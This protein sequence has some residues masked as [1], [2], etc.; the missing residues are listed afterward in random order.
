MDQL[1]Q[2]PIEDNRQDFE[3]QVDDNEIYQLQKLQR[4]QERH[5]T[6]EEYF[7]EEISDFTDELEKA[8]HFAMQEEMEGAI[9]SKDAHMQTNV[10]YL[11][12][13]WFS[14][15]NKVRTMV[16]SLMNP[17]LRRA[18]EDRATVAGV[19]QI[20]DGLKK[21]VDELLF[22]SAKMTT[23]G[24]QIEEIASRMNQ[25]EADKKVYEARVGQELKAM[26]SNI[27]MC[28]EK[29]SV[30]TNLSNGF[31]KQ[32]EILRMEVSSF[33]EE[34]N[35]VKANFSKELQAFTKE[36]RI[37][38]HT[39]D[40]K[41]KHLQEQ[42]QLVK[43]YTTTHEDVIKKTDT[44]VETYKKQLEELYEGLNIALTTKLDSSI[45][46]G[47]LD[48]ISKDVYFVKVIAQDV[49]NTINHIEHYL[50]KYQQVKTQNQITEAMV[51]VLPRKMIKRLKKYTSQR[52]SL[53]L[54]DIKS[55][56]LNMKSTLNKATFH[57]PQIRDVLVNKAEGNLVIE[58]DPSDLFRRTVMNQTQNSLQ[59]STD[60]NRNQ[61]S[62]RYIITYPDLS[63]HDQEK[64]T[65]NIR[66]QEES[67]S[68]ERDQRFGETFKSM[69]SMRSSKSKWI[70][71]ESGAS[72]LN[73]PMKFRMKKA[74]KIHNLPRRNP[75]ISV[76]ELE[77]SV[78]KR[79]LDHNDHS[80]SRLNASK[81]HSN[82][83]HRKSIQVRA[84]NV[85]NQFAKD[86]VLESFKHEQ[87]LDLTDSD[88]FD[89]IS[90]RKIELEDLNDEL[91]LKIKGND[92]VLDKIREEQAEFKTLIEMRIEILRS[93]TRAH[94]ENQL[95]N[96]Q[97]EIENKL[98][99]KEEDLI[100]LIQVQ[101]GLLENEKVRRAREKSDTTIEIKK[102]IQSGKKASKLCENVQTGLD[103]LAEMIKT[104]I[105]TTQISQALEIQDEVDRKSIALMGYQLDNNNQFFSHP[106]N[107]EKN[108]KQ[109]RKNSFFNDSSLIT[110]GNGNN[111]SSM[112]IDPLINQINNHQQTVNRTLNISKSLQNLTTL[113]PK[114]PLLRNIMEN[115]SSN[116]VVSINKD[117]ISCSN[118][119]AIVIKGFKMACLSYQSSPLT[120]KGQTYDRQGLIS[121]KGQ[122]LNRTWNRLKQK[123]PWCMETNNTR[124]TETDT[125]DMDHQ[126]FV[127][128]TL[129]DR[130]YFDDQP[131]LNLFDN[132]IIKGIKNNETI[133]QQDPLLK[134]D[135][136]KIGM[137]NSNKKQSLILPKIEARN[138]LIN[139]STSVIQLQKDFEQ[140]QKLVIE[141]YQT[142]GGNLKDKKLSSKTIIKTVRADPD[143]MKNQKEEYKLAAGFMTSRS[144]S[145]HT[146]MGR[147][148][149]F[150]Q[151]QS[152]MLS[153]GHIGSALM[154]TR[155]ITNLDRTENDQEPQSPQSDIDNNLNETKEDKIGNQYLKRIIQFSKQNDS[156]SKM[157][158]KLWK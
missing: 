66:P 24:G 40:Q 150:H 135:D 100:R 97:I 114:Q 34:I 25:V 3:I 144:M 132:E 154:A 43:G 157:L 53:F 119:T 124:D 87:H 70:K 71:R 153:S 94:V 77:N 109:D 151:S 26:S 129:L 149:A 86:K 55:N 76:N 13:D 1:E 16:L 105:E 7:N 99:A 140:R 158:K 128:N 110:G 133:L 141:N 73:S 98:K 82:N 29:I 67:S 17:F 125:T 62:K 85:H 27:Q 31:K 103:N 130:R 44:I 49:D 92:E 19:K 37:I 120:F 138:L 118:Q 95:Y 41:V 142:L 72:G 45:F 155:S 106:L 32:G 23:R 152:D 108:T 14:M 54:D 18:E 143:Q 15:Q 8:S 96:K 4:H 47:E 35:K 42:F 146:P 91:L 148:S 123:V 50:D 61:L 52:Y 134:L 80:H 68:C 89:V 122:I 60:N 5:P 101:E 117:C 48:K 22:I 12:F 36:L 63:K 137:E 75:D 107:Q 90:E 111:D 104:I 6:Q 116:N 81:K 78:E 156:S 33:Y 10:K 9:A 136:I 112:L 102:A 56:D 145:K 65:V 131:S 139:S 74:L 21:K 46:K 121:I 69:R 51:N 127:N 20:N 30:V 115:K 39:Y 59:I 88:N 83:D 2:Q 64:C 93:E 38:D 11:N 113:K 58:E 79:R 126:N 84:S 28:N 57:I 147:L